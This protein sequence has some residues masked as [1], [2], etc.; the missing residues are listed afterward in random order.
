MATSEAFTPTPS[1]VKYENGPGA[2]THGAGS[3]VWDD[4]P[5][6]RKEADTVS[7]PATEM[8]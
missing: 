1:G 6:P 2:T 8:L 7:V 3:A 4:T 5:T